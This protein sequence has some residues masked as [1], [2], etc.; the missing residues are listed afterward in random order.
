MTDET[1]FPAAARLTTSEVAKLTGAVLADPSRGSVVITDVAAAANAGEG[2][3]AFVEGRKQASLLTEL[4]ASAVLC[5]ADLTD[6][7]PAG[8]VALVTP[9]PHYAF[10]LIA[11]HFFPTAAQPTAV[12]GENGI[13]PHAIVHPSARIEE[14]AVVEAGAVVGEGAAI[15]AGTV[16]APYAVIGRS[17]RIGRNGFI[18]PHTSVQNAHI[19]NRVV[20]HGGVRIGQDGFGYVGGPRGPMKIPQLGRVIIQ[21]DVEI[22]AG[23][24]IDR[25][26]LDDTVIGENTKID[27]L[28][29]IAHNVRIG[30]HCLIASHCGISGSTVLG[31]GVMMGGRVG[32]ADHLTIGSGAQLAA[33]SGVMNDVPAG[34]KW[35]GMPAQPLREFFRNVAAL[36]RLASGAAKE[37]KSDV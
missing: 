9:K 32:L 10:A 36:R 22:G 4:K 18:G 21:D 12:T 20:I 15:G 25:G 24:T 17:C 11:G 29:Q 2:D 13:S 16:I 23:T 26:A 30:R 8:V 1:F 34:E 19:G 3:L 31:D 28:V 35:A 37:K 33:A 27:N 14:G 6:S 7:V 5:P